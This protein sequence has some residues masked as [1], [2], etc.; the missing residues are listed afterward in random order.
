MLDAAGRSEQYL[1]TNGVTLRTIV[2]GDGPLV[3]LLH[4]FP[5]CWYLWRHQI[6]PLK[7]AGFRVAVPDQR[8]YGPSSRP[9]RIEDYNILELAADVIGL[10]EALGQEKFYLVGHDWGCIVA[11]Y[12]ALLY[13]HRLHCVMG[14][15][16]PNQPIGP[17]AVNPPGLDELFWYIRYFQN[18]GIA[19]KEFEADID[20]TFRSFNGAR[21]E[22][23][24]TGPKQREAT[25][26]GDG[27][28]A[29]KLLPTITEEDHAYYVASFT[30]SGFRGPINWYR[31]MGRIPTLTPW[32]EGAQIQV[33][34]YF[35]AGSDD[36]VL[37]FTPNSFDRQDRNFADLRGKQLIDGAG[38]WVQEEKA[39]AV[40]AAITSFLTSMREEVGG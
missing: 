27:P 36:P 3:I 33:P 5:R 34:A 20:R 8:G 30:E 14:L 10:A 2:E 39:D 11:W 7:A 21:G 9:E 25:F 38:H 28:I 24:P 31:N 32:L 17:A 16:V 29:N 4:G 37:K 13:P 19:E 23:A 40:N 15:S 35:L 26:L 6:D 1:D 12:T 18:P 22:G